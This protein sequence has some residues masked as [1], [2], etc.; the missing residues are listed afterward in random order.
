M[1]AEPICIEFR[2][3]AGAAELAG[4]RLIA[5]HIPAGAS[6]TDVIQ[7]LLRDYPQLQPLA[8]MSRWALGTE[9]I[10]GQFQFTQVGCVAMI[11]PVSGG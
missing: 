2:L 5:V 3:F 7:A 8:E 4:A 6:L 1:N 9:F 10:S 11:P